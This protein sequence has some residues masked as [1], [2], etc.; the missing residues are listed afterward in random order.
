MATPSLPDYASNTGVVRHVSVTQKLASGTEIA[1]ITVNG[2]KTT[3]YAPNSTGPSSTTVV[4]TPELTTGT[5]IGSIK[6]NSTSKDLFAPSAGFL[7]ADD[8]N[9]R[10]VRSSIADS[11]INASTGAVK[12]LGIR[13]D[14]SG[15]AQ[16]I[17]QPKETWIFEDLDG[18]TT[19]KT[20][21]I[22][23]TPQ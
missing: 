22:E 6:V 16:I 10:K 4:V 3:I 14:S 7:L 13:K 12:A 15:N 21:Y 1:D 20:V 23:A 19:E 18:N 11:D 9:T 5:K 8:G 2:T 17:L